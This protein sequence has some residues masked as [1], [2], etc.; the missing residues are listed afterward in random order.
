MT[1]DHELEA[2][3]LTKLRSYYLPDSL[4]AIA[5]FYLRLMGIQHGPVKVDSMRIAL[6]AEALALKIG[7]DPL[8]SFLG[9]LFH[10]IGKLYF[11]GHLFDGR[12]IS[13]AEYEALK[14]HARIGFEV[15]KEIHPLIAMCAGLHHS[16]KPQEG[17]ITPADFPSEW[18]SKTIQEGGKLAIIVSIADFINAAIYRHTRVRDGSNSNGNGLRAMLQEKY[19]E[20][21]AIVEAALTVLSENKK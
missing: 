20:H 19:P 8:N 13:D 17:G 7:Q 3:I 21:Q 5:S 1:P 9:G 10:D 18:D 15:W 12:E 11:P 2:L 4:T 14:Q 16:Y 6:F